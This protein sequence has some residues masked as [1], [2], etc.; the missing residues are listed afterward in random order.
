MEEAVDP[1]ATDTEA[2]GQD[3][4]HLSAYFYSDDGLLASTQVAGLHHVFTTLMGVFNQ[5][6]LH[7]NVVNTVIMD[8]NPC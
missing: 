8:C 5:V 1:G 3:V 2:F 7:T 4:Q 6:G